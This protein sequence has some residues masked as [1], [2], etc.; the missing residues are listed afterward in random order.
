MRTR[1]RGWQEE[2]AGASDAI[3]VDGTG[4]RN[5]AYTV[6]VYV[7][8]DKYGAVIRG[9]DQRSDEGRRHIKSSMCSS[10]PSCWLCVQSEAFFGRLA[11]GGIAAAG[12]SN[13]LERG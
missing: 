6:S 5:D 9:A 2:S 7:I 12:C 13:P 8:M 1:G 4:V 3:T 10:T 11:C